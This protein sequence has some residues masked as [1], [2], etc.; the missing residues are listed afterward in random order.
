MGGGREAGVDSGALDHTPLTHQHG[1]PTPKGVL[2]GGE[3]SLR[4]E[5]LGVLALADPF[6][7]EPDL[8][9]RVGVGGIKKTNARK[10]MG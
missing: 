10:N 9:A 3:T 4:S 1:V 5:Q 6:D 7:L 8:C 2:F